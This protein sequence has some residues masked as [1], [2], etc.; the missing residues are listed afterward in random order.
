M[1]EPGQP[2]LPFLSE[3]LAVPLAQKRG[4]ASAAAR[5]CESRLKNQCCLHPV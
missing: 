2:E 4:S 3:M 1:S 5:L